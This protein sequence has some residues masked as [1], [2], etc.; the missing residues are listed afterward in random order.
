MSLY[1]IILNISY[2]IFI[3][4]AAYLYIPNMYKVFFFANSSSAYFLML[5]MVI[6]LI[7]IITLP[8]Y[9]ISRYIGLQSC[10]QKADSLDNFAFLCGIFAGAPIMVIN[11]ISFFDV[12][13]KGS[14]FGCAVAILNGF[15]LWH[16]TRHNIIDGE[17]KRQKAKERNGL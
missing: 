15:L 2:S 7:Y 6:V 8:N 11:L 3:G 14:W 9:F 5:I 4:I 10:F 13:L 1:R 16:C 17:K 12:W